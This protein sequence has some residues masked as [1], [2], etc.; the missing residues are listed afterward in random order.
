MSRRTRVCA[1]RSAWGLAPLLLTGLSACDLQVVNPGVIADQDL[2]RPEAGP[3]VLVGAVADVEVAVN[4]TALHA[5]LASDEL[6][7]SGTRSWLDFFSRGD[8]QSKDT[9]V[10]WEPVA[11]AIWVT[12]KGVAR[13][14][15]SQ[16][17]PA[18]NLLVAAAHVWAGYALRIAGDLFCEATF[19]GGPAE[20]NAAY[21]ER[22]IQHFTQGRAIAGAMNADSLV[23]A[24]TA[25]LA[26][27]YLILGKYVEAAAEAAKI[28]DSYL[29][30]ARRSDNSTRENNLIWSE[31]HTQSQV[32]VWGTPIEKL[33]P[34]G[35][36][37]TRWQDMKRLGAGGKVPFYRQLKYTDRGADIPLAKGWEMR[38]IEAEAKLRAED[39]AGAMALINK[40]RAAFGV[41]PKSAAT[42]AE[43]WQ[44][45]D[46]ERLVT[47]WLEGRRLKDNARFFEQGVNRYLEGRDKC[48]PFSDSEIN[49]NPNL[50]K[51]G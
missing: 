51:V 18:K 36:P 33:G 34:N 8:I 21:Y 5:G 44:A 14:T 32:T 11:R 6:N 46:H 2:E 27:A 19:D 25:G 50:R 15:M 40:V 3:V 29:W 4:N 10:T 9:N 49:S 39:V 48:F 31:T 20:P 13:L 1:R 16:P 24:A 35:D 12:E 38:L 22:A 47:L 30:V 37:R 17:E 41:A 28:P 42:A 43:A 26:Q 45:L 7:F 23:K